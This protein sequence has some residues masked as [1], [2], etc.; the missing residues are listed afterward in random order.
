MQIV[1]VPL[2]VKEVDWMH[3]NHLLLVHPQLVHLQPVG[4]IQNSVSGNQKNLHNYH[5]CVIWDKKRSPPPNIITCIEFSARSVTK[6][7]AV[8]HTVYT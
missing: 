6:F 2:P 5:D 4:W 1:K 3:L 8:V 7:L